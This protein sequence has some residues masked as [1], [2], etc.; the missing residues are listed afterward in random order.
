MICWC[1]RAPQELVGSGALSAGGAGGANVQGVV[2]AQKVTSKSRAFID[3]AT[4][5][6]NSSEAASQSVSVQAQ[7]DTELVS[8]SGSGGV[9]DC[10][11]RY[12]R[13]CDDPGKRKPKP[14]LMMMR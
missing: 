2:M 10:R 5:N 11:G 1:V 7:S 12:H 4:I 6:D 14:I 9:G 8:F 3:D 13:R